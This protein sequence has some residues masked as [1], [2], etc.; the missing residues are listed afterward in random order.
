MSM[1]KTVIFDPHFHRQKTILKMAE[2]TGFK[3]KAI[4]GNAIAYTM[5]LVKSEDT[6]K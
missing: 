4:Y 5:H 6:S 1:K 2:Q 3:L